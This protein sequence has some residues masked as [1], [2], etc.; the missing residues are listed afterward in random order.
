MYYITIP[1]QSPATEHQPTATERE[2]AHSVIEMETK[3]D[4]EWYATQYKGHQW[5]HVQALA[6][7][8]LEREFSE[9]E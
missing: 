4:V 9:I 5:T 2:D 6:E 7:I 3:A 8:I 1:H